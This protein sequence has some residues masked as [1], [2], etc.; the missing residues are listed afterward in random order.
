VVGSFAHTPRSLIV[1]PFAGAG[2]S[3]RQVVG[4]PWMA[5]SGARVTVGLAVEWLGV[6][7]LEAG[8]GTQ[9]HMAGFAFDVT[10]DFWDIL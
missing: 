8:F 9:S 3:D 1:A 7:R 5:T 10:R 2:W 6:F 4:T